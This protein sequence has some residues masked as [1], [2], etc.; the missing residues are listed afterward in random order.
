MTNTIYKYPIPITH[1]PTIEIPQY[2]I[3]RHIGVQDGSLFAWV[4]V[5]AD[6][7]K[8]TRHFRV[9][10]TGHPALDLSDWVYLGTGL[11]EQGQL[12]LHVYELLHKN[13]TQS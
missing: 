7:P 9:I 13:T 8:V 1:R 6:A 4:E 11:L 10:G 5:D 3:V 2:G 12:V